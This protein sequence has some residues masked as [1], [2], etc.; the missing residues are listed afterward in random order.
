MPQQFS[1]PE[2]ASIN[3]DIEEIENNYFPTTIPPERK[4][5]NAFQYLCLSVVTNT[6]V[7]D[8]DDEDVVDGS[9]E[10]GID[11]IHLVEVNDKVTIDL[12][13]CKSSYSKNYSAK[14]IDNI[15]TGLGYVFEESRSIVKDLPNLKLKAKIIDIRENKE[16][17]VRVNVNY[18]VF[19]GNKTYPNMLRKAKEI[20]GRYTQFF[21][22]Q[23]PNANIYF[24]FWDSKKLFIEKTKISE[25]LKDEL[26]T[27]PYYDIGRRIRSEVQTENEIEGYL[28]TFKAEE[29]AKLVHQYGDKLFEKNIRGWLRYSKKNLEIYDSC[30]TENS[31]L[32]WFL[33]NGITMIGDHVF[34]D[35]DK[36]QWRVKNL[37]IVNGQQTA[38]M[39]YEAYR[40]GK[41]K[42]D[43]K[44]MCRIYKTNDDK[45]INKIT[46]ATNTQSSIGSRD[47]MS[48][49]SKQIALQKYF[50]TKGYFY[51]RQKGEVYDKKEYKKIINSKKMAQISL[52]VLCK[53]PSL[54]RK[55]IE[56]N[57]FNS[58]K[59]YYQIFNHD[60]K[61]LIFSYLLY[62]YCDNKR[63]IEDPISYF[64]PLHLACIIFSQ[65]EKELL[66]DVDTSIQKLE[67]D[68]LDLQTTY[69]QSKK[70]LKGLIPSSKIE[71]GSIGNYLSRIEVDENLMKLLSEKATNKV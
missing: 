31:N 39:I 15:K 8:I 34:P 5:S 18:C 54:A 1:D 23:Y 67:A 52:A 68:K 19:N 12:F 40:N 50:E 61:K 60:P 27:I 65:K 33:N 20:E 66:T 35:D 59:Y 58:D 7:K 17:I 3:L 28:T 51:E 63:N 36:A 4:R 44:V 24:I 57:F 38:R 6:E 46:K 32:F 56:D 10:E 11:I 71:D 22:S 37:Q 26:I 55:N 13:N 43:V 21:K 69:S 45:F 16:K 9:D 53:K 25:S 49:E 64:A 2:K 47:L 70:L 48:N 42:S 30:V 41:L 14:D 29:I 62:N